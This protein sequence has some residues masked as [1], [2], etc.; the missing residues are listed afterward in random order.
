GACLFADA[1]LATADVARRAGHVA[2][3]EARRAA[4]G[5]GARWAPAGSLRPPVE[6]RLF[7]GFQIEM[8][9]RPLDLSTC[10]PRVRALLRLLAAHGG[11]P[12]HREAIQSA[13]WA[14]AP[15]DSG[16]RNVHVAVSSLRQAL[17]PG[18][19]RVGF[20]LLVRD[21]DAYRLALGPGLSID[22]VAFEAD[23]GQ[24][25]QARAAGDVERALACYGSALDRYAG[26]LLPE[27]GAAEWVVERRESCRS[28]AAEAAQ[29]LA[30]LRLARGDADGAAQ[31]A[32]LGLRIDRY[33]DPLWRLVVCAR[34][35]AGDHVAAQRARA[36]YARVLAELGVAPPA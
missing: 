8:D 19:A 24:G 27:D 10:K 31:A 16:G 20:T 11:R 23:L 12:L 6:V 21:G 32:A 3:A 7:G 17:E 15:P 2:L 30:E 9:G 13:L 25:R 28:A 4:T 29:A 35:Q 5:L 22:L 26:E 14:D 18:V 1:A 36:E 33:H 34:E